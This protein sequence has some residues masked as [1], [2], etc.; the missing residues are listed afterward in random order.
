MALRT[1]VEL[2]DQINVLLATNITRDLSAADLRSVFN[3]VVDSLGFLTDI[4]TVTPGAEVNRTAAQIAAALDG[5]LLGDA[6]RSRISGQALVDAIDAALSPDTAWR[7]AHTVRRTAAEI[8]AAINSA[9][10][11][12]A[13]QTGGTQTGGITVN[14]AED[15]AGALLAATAFFTYDSSTNALTLAIP[16]GYILPAMLLTTSAANKTAFRTALGVEAS[17]AVRPDGSVAFTATIAGIA[18]VADADLVTK[19]YA[20]ANYGGGSVPVTAHDLI[21]G[22]SADTSI[23][24]SEIT[25]GVE[26]PTNSLVLPTESGSLYM[27]IW[28]ADADGGDPSEVHISGALNSRNLFATATARIVDTIAGQLIVS[29]NTFNAALTGGET[30]RVV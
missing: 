28:R 29:V 8:V 10:L 24:D 15:A 17:G 20:D 22:W 6:W 30:V 5:Y 18:P 3:D 14:Q 25:A 9:L 12:D 23:S 26:S 1:K 2:E 16:N 27:F 7:T 21:A 19:A 11:S 4:P 13:W